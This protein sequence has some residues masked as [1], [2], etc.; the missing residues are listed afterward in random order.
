MYEGQYEAYNIFSQQ[1]YWSCSVCNRKNNTNRQ[2]EF[3][4]NNEMKLKI[5]SSNFNSIHLP[6]YRK[7]PGI[8]KIKFIE[9]AVLARENDAYF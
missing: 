3:I 1:F 4:Y 6:S 8:F 2:S 9:E 5:M 7:R